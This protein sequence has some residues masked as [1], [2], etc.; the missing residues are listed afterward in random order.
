M[1]L[2]T[3]FKGTGP[4]FSPVVSQNSKTDMLMLHVSSLF[5]AS[6]SESSVRAMDFLIKRITNIGVYQPLEEFS[7]NFFSLCANFCQCYLEK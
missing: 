4:I 3:F 7:L 2:R 5:R 1:F 6:I